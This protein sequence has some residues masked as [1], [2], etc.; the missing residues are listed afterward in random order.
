MKTPTKHF[1]LFTL[2]FLL[3]SYA[4]IAQPIW[5]TSGA[6]IGDTS[7]YLYTTSWTGLKLTLPTTTNQDSLRTLDISGN[8]DGIHIYCVEESPMYLNINTSTEDSLNCGIYKWTNQDRYFGVF[9]VNGTNPSYTVKY[10]YA[11]DPKVTGGNEP[12]LVIYNRPTNADTV[13]N[14]WA[15]INAS[16][17]MGG[18]TLTGMNRTGRNE[19]LLGLKQPP[20]PIELLSFNARWAEKERKNALLTWLTSTEINSDY[21]EVQR[22][23][24]GQHFSPIGQVDAAGN[25]N[26]TRQYTFLDD[27][28]PLNDEAGNTAWYYRLRYVD[29]DGSFSYS[30]IR[31]LSRGRLEILNLW[32]NPARDNI[33][34][35][36][37]TNRDSGLDL[38]VFDALGQTV[39]SQ[40]MQLSKGSHKVQ[41]DISSLARSTYILRV[42]TLTGSY[43]SQKQL[44]V[45]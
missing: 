14:A 9:L 33:S 19:Y 38:S 36:I 20:L 31:A 8:P 42:S 28:I 12:N 35:L 27:N 29:N 18:D 23:A 1:I 17:E 21:F 44:L 2:S 24:D 39:I 15:D 40:Y 25:S 11:A 6:A 45:Q 30:Q 43:M 32:P 37:Y 34:L 26:S 22:S 7:A 10:F 16:L 3:G 4:A 41:L 5:T 13:C